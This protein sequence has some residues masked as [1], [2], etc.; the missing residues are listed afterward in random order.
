MGLEITRKKNG[1][2]RSKWWYG[3]FTVGGK[4]ACIKLGVKIEGRVPETLRKIGDMEFERSRIKAQLKLD[5]LIKEARSHQCAEQHLERLYELKSGNQMTQVAL[6]DLES[7]WLSLPAKK[8]R[9][10]TWEKNQCA[11]LK[12]FR[13][14]IQAH[15][16]SVR[17][18]SQTTSRMALSWL[19]TLEDKGYAPSTY[20]DKMH[21]V[22]RFY[23]KAGPDIGVMKNPFANVPSKDCETIHHQ[24]FSQ[25]ELNALLKHSTGAIHSIILVG[26]CTGMRL[27]DCCQMKWTEVDLAEGFLMVKT[28]KTGEFAE[29]PLFPVLRDEIQRQ[30]QAGEYVFP[31]A[32]ALYQNRNFGISWRLRQVFKDAGI[33][34]KQK[35]ED[36]IQDATIKGFHSLRTTWITM[37]LSA[38]VPMELVRRVTGHST[39]EIVL[40]HYFRPGREAFRAALANGLPKL[41][42]GGEE[43]CFDLP[44]EVL[45][46][47]KEVELLSPEE[48]VK[49]FKALV[50]KVADMTDAEKEAV[51]LAA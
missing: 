22:K 6:E 4:S 2:L 48:V 20:N 43:E 36:R 3:R 33:E 14:H 32:A 47:G 42:T 16:P 25:K 38:G 39:V 30:K 26:M 5:E 49:K 40:K 12:T 15:Y 50:E 46:L 21:L 35:C 13:Q 24:P 45:E 11:T 28:S 19:R 29:I 44:R 51:V 31:E 8:K 18:L 41:L 7:F 37:A 34:T 9:S 10:A 1:S 27:G 23:T 17:Y